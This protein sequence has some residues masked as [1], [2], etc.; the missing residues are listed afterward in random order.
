M[1]ETKSQYPQK[2]NVWA[3]IIGT[4]IIGPFFINGTLTA[5]K[6]L[7]MLRDDIVPAIRNIFD[8]NFE[9]VWFQQD[10]GPPHFGLEVR[11][12]LDDTFAE[13]WIGRRETIEWP[14]RSPE[15]NPLDFFFWDYLKDRV[16]RIKPRNLDDLR[17]R[18]TTE[19]TLITIE[20]LENVS[21]NFYYRLGHCQT[22]QG[23]QFE[24]LL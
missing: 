1:R 6:Y 23:E 3:R 24:H 16:Y 21:S 22:V 14:P 15:M 18:I 13:R 5:E 10:G 9:T 2:L 11:N 20:I 19:V 8:L 4:H 12:V 7:T 17:H